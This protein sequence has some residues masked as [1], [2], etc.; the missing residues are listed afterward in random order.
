MDTVKQPNPTEP[1]KNS[2][3]AQLRMSMVNR[4]IASLKNKPALTQSIDLVEMFDLETKNEG[5][6]K[7][8]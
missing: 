7:N 1:R 4:F 5:S 8:D 3:I 2:E 6:K